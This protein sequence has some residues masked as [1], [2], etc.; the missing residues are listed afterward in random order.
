MAKPFQDLFNGANNGAA[1]RALL[2]TSPFPYRFGTSSHD[3]FT[4]N[5][6]RES[7]FGG[8]GTDTVNY[9]NSTGRVSVNLTTGRGRGGSAHDD[10][11]SSIENVVGSN[12]GDALTGNNASNTLHGGDGNDTF[13][14]SKGNDQLFGGEGDDDTVVYSNNNKAIDADLTAH[15]VNKGAGN[16]I[17]RIDGIENVVGSNYGDT[18]TGDEK[19]NELNGRGGNDT[20]FGS[21]GDDT[22]IGGDD[23]DTVDYSDNDQAISANLARNAVTKGDG[24]GTDTISGIENVVGSNYDDI[25]TG[26]EKDNELDGRGGND[27]FYGSKGNDTLIGGDDVGTVDTVDYGYYG[28]LD[29]GVN[30]NL[31]TNSVDKGD[32]NGQDSVSGIEGVVGTRF[33]DVME[34]SEADEFFWG[35]GGDDVLSGGAGNDTMTG[36]LDADVFKFESGPDENHGN[37]VITDFTVGIDKIDLSGTEVDDFEDLLNYEPSDPQ[38]EWGDRYMVQ[39]GDNVVIYTNDGAEG[40][41]ITLKDVNIDNLSD[42]DFIF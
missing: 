8:T 27:T 21:K 23:V 31:A 34:G 22:L 19:D 14:G 24:N 25:L 1:L 40:D 36:G 28:S 38:S 37:D 15:R 7:Y 3:N 11:Y 6:S 12:F 9:E 2:P 35:Q 39:E 4:A 20:F 42:N 30:V 32:G 5:S 41:S 16:G 29:Q 18:L 33:G 10:T 17:D 13:G 26:D